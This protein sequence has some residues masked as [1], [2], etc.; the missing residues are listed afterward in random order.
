MIPGLI[1]IP[2]LDCA[3][4]IRE[5]VKTGVTRAKIARILN[6]P[7]NTLKGW[8]EGGAKPRWQHGQALLIL[9]SHCGI[10]QHKA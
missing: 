10:P 5:I 2:E 3:F 8:E 7:F 6:V 9:H 1:Q 4:L